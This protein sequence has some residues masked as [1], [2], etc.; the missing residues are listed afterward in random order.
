MATPLSARALEPSLYG[1]VNPKTLVEESQRWISGFEQ[2]SIA[3]MANVTLLD[4]CN[5]GIAEE[6]IERS[7]SRGLGEYLPFTIQAEVECS[8]MGGIREDWEQ[9]ALD[10]LRACRQKAVE[11]EFW[12][13]RLARAANTDDPGSNPN[14]FLAN[15]DST[16]VTPSPGTAVRA[17]YGLALLEGALAD[18]GCG[19]RGFIHAPVSV[20]SVLPLKDRTGE[21][22]LTTTIGNYVIA[23]D[24]YTGTGTDGAATSGSSVWLYATGPVYVRL[25]DEQ[26]VDP[27]MRRSINTTTNDIRVTAEQEAAVVWDGCAHF[28][29]LVDLAL[30]YA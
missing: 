8:V 16:D 21:G 23:G 15:G 14:R 9:N 25:G 10:A 12:E 19:G 28:R 22:I 30:D 3:C 4:T 24:G 5:S 29:V 6:V 13:G 18:A 27:D 26:V 17:R 1:L 11:I 20:A 2:E 7:G